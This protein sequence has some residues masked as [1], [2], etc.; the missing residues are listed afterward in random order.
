MASLKFKTL[1]QAAEARQGYKSRS[2]G[3][4][5]I[6]DRAFSDQVDPKMLYPL[7]F[8]RANLPDHGSPW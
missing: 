1:V 5:A 6:V 8:Y 3:Q 4:A 7:Y 2:R